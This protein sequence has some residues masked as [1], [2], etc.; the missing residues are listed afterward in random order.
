MF[1]V[2]LKSKRI[3]GGTNKNPSRFVKLNLPGITDSDL[4]YMKV[5]ISKLLH[6]LWFNVIIMVMFGTSRIRAKLNLEHCTALKWSNNKK[7]VFQIWWV[8]NDIKQNRKLITISQLACLK[9]DKRP[10]P[11]LPS[12]LNWQLPY[13]L[14]FA[15]ASRVCK[16]PSIQ[17]CLQ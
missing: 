13:I 10:K 4:T 16:F 7:L 9:P 3:C 12:D 2:R 17:R 14:R 6:S 5:G 15:T 11:T 8:N 1:S